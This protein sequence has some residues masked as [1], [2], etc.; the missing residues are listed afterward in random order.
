[1]NNMEKNP[2]MR[3]MKL[4]LEKEIKKEIKI[5]TKKIKYKNIND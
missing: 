5:K 3:K 2:K 4:I 1:M